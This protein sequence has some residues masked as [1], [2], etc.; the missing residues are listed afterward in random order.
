M[1]Q[2]SFQEFVRGKNFVKGAMLYSTR[3]SE[4]QIVVDFN[5]K[6]QAVAVEYEGVHDVGDGSQYWKLYY[7][8]GSGFNDNECVKFQIDGKQVRLRFVLQSVNGFY[9]FKL[10]PSNVKDVI[11]IEKTPDQQRK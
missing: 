2:S 9:G 11:S 6:S 3:G 10:A 4:D 5:T 8:N 1:Q 7:D